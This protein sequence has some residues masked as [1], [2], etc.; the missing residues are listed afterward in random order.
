[1]TK[2]EKKF[3]CGLIEASIF[4]NEVLQNGNQ[5]K[6]KK[7]VFQ[8]RYK[9]KD[10]WKTTHTLDINDLPKAI[11]VLKKSYEYLVLSPESV[12]EEDIREDRSAE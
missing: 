7:V 12:G 6:V 4:E 9:G 1:M 8:K 3:H 11:L 5:F 10:G 2:P